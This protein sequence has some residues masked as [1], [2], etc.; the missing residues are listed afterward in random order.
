MTRPSAEVART[1]RLI[2]YWLPVLLML[3]LQFVFST[4]WFSSDHTSRFILPLLRFLL[5]QLGMDQLILLHHVIRKAGHVTEYCVLGVLLYRAVH[6]DIRNP[7]TVRI[8]TIAG[9]A[10]AA[11][12]DE[13]HQSFV[14]ART[15]S[16]GDIG[17]DFIGG[18]CAILLMTVWRFRRVAE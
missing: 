3:V 16:I 14:P 9:I 7:M 5:P 18:V 6:I 4:D 12:M 17:F 13:L 1:S 8:L 15:S 11:V 2:Q 10:A